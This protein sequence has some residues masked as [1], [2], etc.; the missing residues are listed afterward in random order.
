MTRDSGREPYDV[1]LDELA[2]HLY[3]FD[4]DGLAR[5]IE[6]FRAAVSLAPSD[7]APRI[8]LGFVLDAAGQADEALDALR[9]AARLD[10]H[11]HDVARAQLLRAVTGLEPALQQWLDGF[12][13]EALSDEAAAIMYLVLGIEE[14]DRG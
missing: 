13:P 5:A 2:T 8:A 1:G 3:G 10:P 11:D 12:E 14:M 6:A 4:D 9:T 7:P